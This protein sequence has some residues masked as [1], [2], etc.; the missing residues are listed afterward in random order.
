M[1]PP[2][3]STLCRDKME[4]IPE[5][6]GS[7]NFTQNLHRSPRGDPLG[8]LQKSR[9]LF[10]VD[11]EPVVPKRVRVRMRSQSDNSEYLIFNFLER[12]TEK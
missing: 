2:V 10:T 4:T 8:S 11:E 5:I 12:S 6:D 9:D 3:T 7:E 1:D